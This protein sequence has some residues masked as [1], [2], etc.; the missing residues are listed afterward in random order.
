MMMR[1]M[2]A[3]IGKDPHVCGTALLIPG[4]C[5]CLDRG[6]FIGG[7]CSLEAFGGIQSAPMFCGRQAS[8]P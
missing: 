7:T 8:W 1:M 2:I 4:A 5:L 3:R 6:E